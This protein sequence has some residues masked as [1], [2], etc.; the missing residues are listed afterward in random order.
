MQTEAGLPRLPEGRSGT[1]EARPGWLLATQ[2]PRHVRYA[3]PVGWRRSP[4]GSGVARPQRYGK[5]HAVLETIAQPADAGQGERDF[6][7][8][9][10][11]PGMRSVGNL[12]LLLGLSHFAQR[13]LSSGD[14]L[15]G[16]W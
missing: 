10:V 14:P 1:C 2:V 5:H 12:G 8:A 15:T 7:L 9:R 11:L 13:F 3:V 4:L 16:G 6:C